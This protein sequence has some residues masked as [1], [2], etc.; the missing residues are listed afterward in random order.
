LL[1][2]VAT[3]TATAMANGHLFSNAGVWA[4]YKRTLIGLWKHTITA[5]PQRTKCL[6]NLAT[7]C[8]LFLQVMA[9]MV[10][11]SSFTGAAVV[12]RSAARSSLA[13]RRR[14]VIV[15]AQTEVSFHSHVHALDSQLP[16]GLS[17]V[18]PC[19]S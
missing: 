5:K 1:A 16:F 17:C 4:L 7:S 19:Q 18:S 12:G 11:L 6:I 3:A 9:T 8:F 13:P 2:D 15:R 10:A 14:A